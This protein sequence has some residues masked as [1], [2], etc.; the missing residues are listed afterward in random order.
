M[1]EAVGLAGALAARQDSIEH[2]YYILPALQPTPVAETSSDSDL[3][4]Q[5]DLRK[6]PKLADAIKTA[7]S[8]YCP[9]LVA[10]A[11]TPRDPVW[12]QQQKLVPQAIVIRYQKGFAGWD[13][14]P[15]D[16]P[17]ARPVYLKM[18]AALARGRRRLAPWDRTPTNRALFPAFHLHDELANFVAAG[19][20]PYEALRAGTIDAARFLH[21]EEEFGT[22]AVGQPC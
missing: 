6:L 13:E 14:D 8:W 11:R 16:S 17:E 21:R 12:L 18:V 5:A 20:T 7:G 4:K 10:Y 1:P 9:T 19:M 3:L 15:L 2:I 22:V